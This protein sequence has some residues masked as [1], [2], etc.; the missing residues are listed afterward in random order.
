[1]QCHLKSLNQKYV[2]RVLGS[3]TRNTRVCMAFCLNARIIRED[4]TNQSPPALSFFHSGDQLERT[5]ATVFGHGSVS[6]VSVSG[7]DCGRAF[8]GF[9]DELRASSF[10]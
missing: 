6:K 2:P 5:N 9:P 1:M 3:L 8:S 4:E 10:P 7:D